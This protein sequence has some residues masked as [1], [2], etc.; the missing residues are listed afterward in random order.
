MAQ[1][2]TPGFPSRGTVARPNPPLDELAR[3]RLAR[4]VAAI[5]INNATPEEITEYLTSGNGFP[6]QVEHLMASPAHRAELLDLADIA[7]A[8]LTA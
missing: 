2:S 3:E 7:V 4:V 1:Q 5:R 6:Q 8:A